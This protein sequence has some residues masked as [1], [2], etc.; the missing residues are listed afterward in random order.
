MAQFLHIDFLNMPSL[1]VSVMHP[2]QTFLAQLGQTTVWAL[3]VVP[4]QMGQKFA[5][6]EQTLAPHCLHGYDAS[7]LQYPLPQSGQWK[8]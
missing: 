6:S 4:P 5:H 7:S 1:L 8:V 3:H 2:P